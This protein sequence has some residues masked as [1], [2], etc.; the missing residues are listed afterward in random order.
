MI[1]PVIADGYLATM[2][3]YDN[4]IYCF[5][6]GKTALTV[7]APTT[8]VVN[9]SKVLIQGTVLDMSPGQAGTPCV[10]AKSMGQ[11]MEYLHMQKPQPTNVTGVP[12]QLLATNKDGT[13]MI[14]IGTVTSDLGGFRYE[15]TPPDADLYTITASFAGDDSYGSSW[16]STGLS[17]S[18]TPST[19]APAAETPAPDNTPIFLGMTAAIVIVAIL[20]VYD[21]IS[22]RKLR[23]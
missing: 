13:K 2:N 14:E 20:V 8:T 17:V 1:H 5:G 19:P 15:W 16:A 7:S 23:K 12:V 10:S 21:I 6:K 18:P 4:Q 9:G 22:V 3:M 11:W